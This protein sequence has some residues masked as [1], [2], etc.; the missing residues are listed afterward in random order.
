[1][2]PMIETSMDGALMAYSEKTLE[3]AM[4]QYSSLRHTVD[5]WNTRKIRIGYIIFAHKVEHTELPFIPFI[6]RQYTDAKF[7]LE[8]L[9]RKI[10]NMKKLKL[11]IKQIHA[12]S[13]DEKKI[14][15]EYTKYQVDKLTNTMR[16]DI[17]NR[18]IV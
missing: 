18:F 16:N 2:S 7:I 3:K 1:M 15:I 11:Y 17:W 4:S 10:P 13:S 8:M 12:K 6:F 5:E 14:Y 9:L